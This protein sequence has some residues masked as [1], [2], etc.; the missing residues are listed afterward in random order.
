MFLPLVQLKNFKFYLMIATDIVIV[1]LSLFLAY[2][3]RFE[4]H[5]DSEYLSQYVALVPFAVGIKLSFF[6]VFG[7][8]RGMWRYTSTGDFWRLVQATIFS[9]LALIAF[10]AY[11]S[12]FSGYPRSVFIIDAILTILGTG[13]LR[14]G[15]RSLYQYPGTPFS[16]ARSFFLLGT[17]ARRGNPTL[18]VGAGDAAEKVC[19]EILEDKDESY[20][21]IGFVDDDATKQGRLLHGIPIRG[22]IA[23]IPRIADTFGVNEILIALPSA[24]G[25]AM[26]IILEACKK[27]NARVKTLPGIKDLIGGKV[28]IRDLRDINYADLLGRTPVTLESHKIAEYLK[29]KTVLITGAGGSIGSELCRQII[30][31]GPERMVLVEG[32]EEHLYAI[33]M[34][35]LHELKFHKYIPILGL[36]Q[37]EM[38][39]D[40][41]FVAFKPDVVFHAAAYKHVP[42]IENNPWQAVDNNILGTKIIMETAARHHT[43]R[44]V[45][46]STD[47]AVRP[48]NVMGASKRATEI[49]MQ[50]VQDSTTTFLAVRFGNVVGSSG[51][52]IPLFRRQIETGGP[53]TVTHPEITRY[54]MTISEA[55]QLIL[56]AGAMGKGGEIFILNMGTPVRIADMAKDLIRLSGKDPED[57]DI[58][59]TGLRPG[60][61]LYEELISQNEGVVRT[62]HDKIMVLSPE[63]ERKYQ[64]P[65]FQKDLGEILKRLTLLALAHDA[66]GI[67]KELGILIPEYTIKET[68]NVLENT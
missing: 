33:Q 43:D 61:K 7:L 48:T 22:K 58:V 63:M 51:S 12:H 11:I 65:E 45:L 21:L 8:Y 1:T 2:L 56:Q 57:I 13:G 15:I 60:E 50:T 27:T 6:F 30:A 37:D 29:G 31:F 68:R 25:P 47:K 54:F 9:Q 55:A 46:V 42:M 3:L 20:H 34:E 28:S 41:V 26:R 40:R 38:L 17:S 66:V 59:F 35:L 44:F 49:I 18:I 67:K 53:V 4:F 14:L 23:D 36:I 10:V 32:C 62:Q 16:L 64:N 24:K 39:M 5:V 52:V 19:R